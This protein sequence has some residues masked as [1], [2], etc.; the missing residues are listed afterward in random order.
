METPCRRLANKCVPQ[1]LVVRA[2]ASVGE[3]WAEWDEKVNPGGMKV[4]VN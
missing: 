1:G 4:W 2:E 3:N